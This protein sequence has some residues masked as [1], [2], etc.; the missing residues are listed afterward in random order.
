M[1]IEALMLG[2]LHTAPVRR[3]GSTSGRQFVGCKVRVALG[4]AAAVFVSV[5]CFSE[6]A[7]EALLALGE[8][9][10]VALAGTLKP[11]AWIDREG[12]ARPSL[13]LVASQVLT[14]YGLKKKRGPVAASSPHEPAHQPVQAGAPRAPG[15]PAGDDLDAGGPDGWLNG[16][17][18]P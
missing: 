6:T 11:G 12:N 17:G 9:D 18:E 4:D 3:T 8:G 13:D 14:A 7:G 1:S 16:G 5:V 2:K 15:P 10:P